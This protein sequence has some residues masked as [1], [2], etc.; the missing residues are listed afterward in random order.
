M[1]SLKCYFIFSDLCIYFTNHRLESIHAH[2]LGLNQGRGRS[3]SRTPL[4]KLFFLFFILPQIN[5]Y[6]HLVS[7]MTGFDWVACFK[8]F[9]PCPG[10]GLRSNKMSM[11][12]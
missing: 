3:Q 12:S 6:G 4:R 5:I 2:P 7:F 9:G 11:T 10:V 8:L 1:S